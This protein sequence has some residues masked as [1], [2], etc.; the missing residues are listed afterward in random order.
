MAKIATIQCIDNMDIVFDYYDSERVPMEGNSTKY[1]ITP[2]RAIRID[3]WSI[4][5]DITDPIISRDHIQFLIDN[6]Y[7][8]TYK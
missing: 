8:G 5:N 1:Y 6:D 3:K 2:N 4:E 7:I